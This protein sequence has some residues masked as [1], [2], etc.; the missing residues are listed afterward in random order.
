MST[1]P[2]RM[3]SPTLDLNRAPSALNPDP[4]PEKPSRPVRPARPPRRSGISFGRIIALL[5]LL[6]V[7]AAGVWFAMRPR[8]ESLVSEASAWIDLSKVPP[9]MRPVVEFLHPSPAEAALWFETIRTSAYVQQKWASLAESV[10]FDFLPGDDTVNAFAGPADGG[11]RKARVVLCGGMVRMARL[12]GALSLVQAA[13]EEQGD[14]KDLDDYLK[15][16]SETVA[17]T[18]GLSSDQVVDLLN[19]FEVGT[20]V[21]EN[22]AAV[23]EA[24]A[25]ADGICKAVLAHEMGHVA[26]GHFRG[27]D[28][29]RTISKNEEAQADLFASSVAASIANGGQM[30]AGQILQWYVLA[31]GET[32]HPGDERFRSHPYS[33]DRLRAAVFANKELAVSLGIDPDEID[34]LVRE[35]KSAVEPP[36]AP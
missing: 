24:K 18:G 14:E 15:R 10:S 3:S 36:A 12:I 20:A 19:E 8:T 21:F 17:E 1:F 35:V 29:N 13:A 27:A 32:Q 26:G 9:E 25:M 31:L 5:V 30:L 33:A 11:L 28:P 16:I 7:V 6:A 23:T 2:P 22:T 34:D 4:N